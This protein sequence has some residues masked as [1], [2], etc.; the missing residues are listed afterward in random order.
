MKRRDLLGRTVAGGLA[1]GGMTALAQTPPG[2]PR[3]DL[4]AKFT[5]SAYAVP[6]TKYSPFTTPD[7]YTYA[8][9]LI[10]EKNRSGKPHAGKV[11]AAVQAHS[12]DIPLFAAGTVA[13]LIDEGYTAYLI[14]FSN[15]EAAGKTLGYGVVQNELD[16][17]NAAKALDAWRPSRSTIAIIVWTTVPWSKSG[18]A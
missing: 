3:S 6:S 2:R 9:D 1:F 15:D 18:P 10:V 13:K 4:P 14:R 8:D 5:P 17:Q 7:Y 12:D 11:L 16:N